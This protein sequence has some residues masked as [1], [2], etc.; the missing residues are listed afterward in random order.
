[1]PQ[2]LEHVLEP[3]RTHRQGAPVLIWP[4]ARPTARSAMNESSVSPDRWLVMMPHPASLESRT[5]ERDEHPRN[6]HSRV[7][8]Q[9]QGPESDSPPAECQSGFLGW[10]P[11]RR[12]MLE[13]GMA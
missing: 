7:C 2:S 10:R 13:Q 4:V 9:R 3:D 12:L 1:M 8:N 5:W 11:D 6:S